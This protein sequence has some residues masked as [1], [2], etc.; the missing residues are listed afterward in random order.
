M[1]RILLLQCLVVEP[2]KKYIRSVNKL[3]RLVFGSYIV[4]FHIDRLDVFS[5][6]PFGFEGRIWDLM[7]S[8]PDHCLSFYFD[9]AS[10]PRPLCVDAF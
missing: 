7:V 8:V 6:F 4:N 2:Y 9:V 5:Y 10:P 1:E 3:V